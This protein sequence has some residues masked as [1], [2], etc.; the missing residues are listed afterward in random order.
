MNDKEVMNQ[1]ST[2]EEDQVEVM[3]GES[4]K[5]S[6]PS[7]KLLIVGGGIFALLLSIVIGFTLLSGG[8]GRADSGSGFEVEDTGDGFG[9]IDDYDSLFEFFYNED[10]VSRLRAAGYTGYEIEQFEMSQASVAYL[11]EEAEEARK[12]LLMETY[13]E[14]QKELLDA[15]SPEYKE[16]ISNTWLQGEAKSVQSEDI[17]TYDTISKKENVDYIKLPARGSQLFV[18]ITMPDGTVLFHAIHPSRWQTLREEGNMIISYDEVTYGGERFII[19]IT[20]VQL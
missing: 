14:L 10:D 15:N 8:D 20:E 5:F 6:L 1:G 17:Y 11:V 3:G 13:Q 9:V 18:K 12:E 19:D 16:L 2:Y 4:R 7:K